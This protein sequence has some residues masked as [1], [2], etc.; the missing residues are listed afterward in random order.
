M[1]R[2]YTWQR[3]TAG[4]ERERV[5]EQTVQTAQTVQRD[6]LQTYRQHS[7]QQ[8]RTQSKAG[9]VGSWKAW[10]RTISLQIDTAL[11]IQ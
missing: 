4:R 6:I 5:V 7:T 8:N 3:D 11:A 2:E 10:E 9:R 1:Y